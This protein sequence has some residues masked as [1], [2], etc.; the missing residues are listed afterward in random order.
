MPAESSINHQPSTINPSPA[1]LGTFYDR[2]WQPEN[3]AAQEE[4]DFHSFQRS[5]DRALGWVLNEGGGLALKIVL[6]IGPGRAR[7][8]EAFARG[9]ARI[10]ALDVSA[11]SLELARERLSRAGFA[12]RIF[13]VVGDA[14]H[15]PFR[16]RA[17]DLT[18]S[19]FVIAHIDTDALGPE[20]ARVLRPGGRA[21][22]VE[23]LSGN[24][25]V[26]L[27]RRFAPTGCRETAPRYVSLGAVRRMA[28]SFPRGWRHREFY[29]FSVI[30]LALRGTPL[31]RPASWLLQLV[32]SPFTTC[33]PLR[34][35]CWV[36]VAEL[37]R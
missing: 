33:G 31:F 7:D 17:F 32:E 28:A 20:L 19:R 18:F 13:C 6:E 16:E 30:A 8:T 14:A 34:G 2:F 35:L 37:R 29:I 21:V 12:D 22:L 23:P 25:L 26:R 4:H 1:E 9:G 10:I 3:R 36:L 24:P 5:L 15:M 27:Y 11:T